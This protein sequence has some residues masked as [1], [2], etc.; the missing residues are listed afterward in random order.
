MA[1]KAAVALFRSRFDG[2]EPKI[3]ACAPGRVNLIGEHT[4]Y[5]D[6]FVFP[7]ALDR[8]TVVVGRAVEGD[9]CT[10]VSAAS[11][12][13]EKDAIVV[14]DR[15]TPS[16]P[17]QRDEPKWANYVRGVL[18]TFDDNRGN[19]PAFEAA[20]ATTVPLGGGLSSSAALEVAAYAFLDALCP[21]HVPRR[22]D[23]EK[24]LL[25]QKAEHEYAGVPCGI[26]DQFI[27]VMG[28]EGHALKIDCRTQ[29]GDLVPLTDPS[30]TVLI[31]NSHVRHELSGSEYPKRVQQCDGAARALGK[32]DRKGLRDLKLEDVE[33]AK[34]KFDDELQYKRAKHVVSENAR[35]NEAAEA[36]HRGDYTLFGKLMNESHE[37]LKN[38]FEVSCVQ[39]DTLTELAREVDGVFGS[40]MTGGGFGGC[41]VTLVKSTAVQAT[42]EHIL[43]KYPEKYPTPTFFTSAPGMG[44]HV[45]TL[46]RAVEE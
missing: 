20:I 38:D 12:I 3:A 25:C 18:A 4:D 14:F 43:K 31:T 41:T 39:L 22:S 32:A 46:A 11:Q 26:M 36:L 42:Q 1:L 37:S 29:K 35:T 33:A 9:R 8:V 27:A 13:D 23:E 28:K 21:D 24:A 6:G 7:M 17:T 10:I 2:S 45:I 34:S 44:A 40:R 16:T 30:V 15:P 19:V 5:C